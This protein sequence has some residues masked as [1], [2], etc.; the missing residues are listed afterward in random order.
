MNEAGH[1]QRALDT[2]KAAADLGDPAAK[3]Y[4]C[5]L[6]VEAYWGASF[7]WLVVGCMRKHG[8]HTDSHLGLVRNLTRLG[9][10][11]I[12]QTWA[13]VERLRNNAWYS[14]KSTPTE[15][16]EAAALWRQIRAWATS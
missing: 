15:V 11:A 6:A 9:E 12:A 14:Y 13:T 7:H 8:G 4:I 5:A 10:A 16:T 1:Q 2:E 3:P